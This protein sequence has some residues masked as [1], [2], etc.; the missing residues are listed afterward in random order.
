MENSSCHLKDHRRLILRL[1]KTEVSV[2][3]FAAAMMNLRLKNQTLSL[4]PKQA[5][6]AFRTND[7]VGSSL[8]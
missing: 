4:D 2:R 7:S 8:T 6:S 1:D 5:S 3:A